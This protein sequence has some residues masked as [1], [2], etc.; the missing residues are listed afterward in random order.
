MQSIVQIAISERFLDGSKN[1]TN[2]IF[3]GIF[4][5]IFTVIDSPI[6]LKYLWYFRHFVKNWG[7]N[8]E[9]GQNRAKRFRDFSKFEQIM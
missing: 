9:F 2:L 7:E 1:G 6:P 8:Y 3:I 5:E 4:I